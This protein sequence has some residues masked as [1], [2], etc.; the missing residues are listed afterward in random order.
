MA[1]QSDTVHLPVLRR[2][3]LAD[4]HD[5]MKA[6][7]V[8]IMKTPY[9]KNVAGAADSEKSAGGLPANQAVPENP[10]NVPEGASHA[11]DNSDVRSAAGNR[12]AACC[13]CEKMLP[14]QER[15]D[16]WAGKKVLVAGLGLLGGSMAKA[17]KKNTACT[18]LGWNRTK[19]VAD[20]A[21]QDGAIDAIADAKDFADCDM[22]IPVLYPE[23]T[24]TFLK[25][26]IPHLKE[27]AVLVDLVGVKTRLVEEIAPLARRYGVRYTGGHPMAGLA[28]AGYE[29]SFAELFLGASMILVPTTATAPGDIADLSTF[30]LRLGFGRIQ[31][32]SAQVHDRMIA[33]TSQLAHVVSNCYVKSPV[34][35]DYVG[36]SGG[37]YKDM[38]RIAC[39]NEKVWKELFLWNKTDLLTEI[40]GLVQNIS[41]LRDALAADDSQRLEALLREGREAKERIDEKNPLQP[42]D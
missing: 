2:A 10:K 3:S 13:P 42:S 6:L 18:V 7:Q 28:K 33:H 29:R 19:S 31:V 39:L 41:S 24:L 30:F 36:F 17:I 34:S 40:D 14:E 25:E 9:Q 1:L 35:A 26:T 16:F 5:G 22:L 12:E 27:G 38:T 21:V 23:A 37:S 32:C 11:M 4:Q 20:K 8:P 15:G